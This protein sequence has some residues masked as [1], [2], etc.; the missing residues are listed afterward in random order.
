MAYVTQKVQLM[1]YV[2]PVTSPEI[3]LN[4]CQVKKYYTSPSSYILHCIRLLGENITELKTPMNNIRVKPVKRE[5]NH[6]DFKI[7][8]LNF[9]KSESFLSLEVVNRVSETQLQGRGN[10]NKLTCLL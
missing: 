2:K 6:Q 3:L 5:M 9:V 8:D 1:E 7:V 10:S 4:G